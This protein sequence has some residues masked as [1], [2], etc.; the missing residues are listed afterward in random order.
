MGEEPSKSRDQISPLKRFLVRQNG[1]S[2]LLSLTLALWPAVHGDSIFA[3]NAYNTSVI[4][5]H[6]DIY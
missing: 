6:H 3:Y 2:A 5:D 1:A 4:D